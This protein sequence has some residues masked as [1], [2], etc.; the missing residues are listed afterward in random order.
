MAM[1]REEM[2][3]KAKSADMANVMR[4]YGIEIVQDM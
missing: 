3:E 1:K 4:Q 2:M